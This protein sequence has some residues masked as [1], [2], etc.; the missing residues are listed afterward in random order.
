M[1]GGN[2][3]VR[4]AARYT[5]KNLS[6]RAEGPGIT[7]V[8]NELAEAG[9]NNNPDKAYSSMHLEVND[10]QVAAKAL[11]AVLFGLGIPLTS[12]YPNVHII[13]GK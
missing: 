6:I 2:E 8:W 7:K 13:A 5:G 1:V 11:G 9:M 3:D 10:P 4:I 12:P